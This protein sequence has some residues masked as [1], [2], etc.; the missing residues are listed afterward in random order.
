MA[1]WSI[2]IIIWQ[3]I[4]FWWANYEFLNNNYYNRIEIF[5]STLFFFQILTYLVRPVFFLK[6]LQRLNRCNQFLALRDWEYFPS[7][8]LLNLSLTVFLPEGNYYLIEPISTYYYPQIPKYPA[9]RGNMRFLRCHKKLNF[10]KTFNFH[11]DEVRGRE[12]GSFLMKLYD[13]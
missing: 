1:N 13:S 11:I 4:I 12:S 9:E 8:E 2:Q 3:Y 6:N 5:W 7:R 10:E